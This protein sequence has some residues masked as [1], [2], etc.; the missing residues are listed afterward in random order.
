VL[1]IPVPAVYEWSSSADNAVELE[2]IIM[3]EALG[4]PLTDF[5]DELTPDSKLA[6]MKEIVSVETKLISLSF[7][8]YS[9][10]NPLSEDEC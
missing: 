3:E 4:T 6:V 9:F 10:L 5:W 1:Q 8:Q 7:S 2:Y